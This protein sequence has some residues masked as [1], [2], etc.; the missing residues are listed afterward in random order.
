MVCSIA[1]KIAVPRLVAT[2][3]RNLWRSRR[4]PCVLRE[5]KRATLCV[6]ELRVAE[7]GEWTV[8]AHQLGTGA[9]LGGDAAARHEDQAAIADRR[10]RTALSKR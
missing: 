5:A 2:V 10:P 4:S 7:L 3:E 8:A 6:A 1:P 9:A